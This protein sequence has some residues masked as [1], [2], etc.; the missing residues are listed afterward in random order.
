M[1]IKLTATTAHL[2][3]EEIMSGDDGEDIGAVWALLDET[4]F[5]AEAILSG[6]ENAEG[7]FYPSEDPEVRRDLEEVLRQLDA[8]LALARQRHATLGTGAGAETAGSGADEAFDAAFETL[9]ETADAAEEAIHEAMAAGLRDLRAR[10]ADNVTMIAVV[11]AFS[12]LAAIGLALA[13]GRNVSGRIQSLA[14]TMKALA[15][16]DLSVAV[17]HAA[18]RDEIGA[19]AQAVE[20]F[21]DNGVKAAALRDERRREREALEKRAQVI[22]GHRLAFERKATGV[23]ESVAAACAELRRT[24]GDMGAFAAETTE[25]AEAA[26]RAAGATSENVQSAAAGAVELSAS[27]TE[28]SQ[29]VEQ[30][31]ANTDKAVNETSGVTAQV[32]GLDE[33]AQ[34]I[35]QVIGIIQDI[36]EQTNLLALNATIEAARAGDAGKGFAVVASEVKS[37]AA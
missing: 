20:V 9:V 8:F 30:S 35:G 36:A 26:T 3:F 34:R 32:R 24:A 22:E 14:A 5:Y 21:K 17:P 4:R 25:Q 16:D 1:E 27:I 12:L 37:L 19:M 15:D 6:G 2:I 11:A 7:K 31:T 10:K 13:I 33:A 23:L 18:D 29:Q 28:I